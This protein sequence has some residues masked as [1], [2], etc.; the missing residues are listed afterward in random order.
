MIFDPSASQF[1]AL[2]L[3]LEVSYSIDTITIRS[4]SVIAFP[5]TW[6]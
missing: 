1:D 3:E 5:G 6:V 2:D 4:E